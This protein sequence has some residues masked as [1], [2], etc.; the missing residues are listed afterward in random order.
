MRLPDFSKLFDEGRLVDSEYGKLTLR[1]HELA[2]LV[3]PSGRI[4]ACDPATSPGS[5]AFTVAIPPGR[6]ALTLSVAHFED[7]DQRVAG[8]LLTLTERE[9]VSWEMALLPGEELSELKEDEVFGYPVESAV[10]CL[11]DAEA[12][13]I[14][15][16][17]LEEDEDFLD[18]AADAMEEHYTDTWSWAEMILRPADGLNLFLFSTGMGDGLYATF[19]GRDA[20]GNVAR[21][22]TD[23]ALVDYDALA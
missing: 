10:G 8:A 5:E 22:V 16:S 12:Q 15:L 3:V 19:L 1:R 11:M 4:V 21:V 17:N 20:A 18:H 6:H 9:V 14:L 23:F 7:E 13:K 2:A